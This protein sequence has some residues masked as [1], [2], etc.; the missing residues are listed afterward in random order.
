MRRGLSGSGARK[1][2]GSLAL[3]PSFPLLP[4]LAIFDLAIALTSPVTKSG[5]PSRPF[6]PEMNGIARQLEDGEGAPKDTRGYLFHFPALGLPDPAGEWVRLKVAIGRRDEC[7]ERML[8]SVLE[9]GH[10]REGTPAYKVIEIELNGAVWFLPTTMPLESDS[11]LEIFQL[12]VHRMPASAAPPSVRGKG[13][14]NATYVFIDRNGPHGKLR[15]EMGPL[16]PFERKPFSD[17]DMLKNLNVIGG[18]EFSIEGVQLYRHCNEPHLHQRDP[19]PPTSAS[20]RPQK[21]AESERA[22]ADA[23]V[24]AH[25]IWHLMTKGMLPEDFQ[26]Q[27]FGDA[28]AAGLLSPSTPFVPNPRQRLAAHIRVSPEPDGDLRGLDYA[29]SSVDEDEEPPTD[30]A[31]WIPF[32]PR[33]AE[34][35]WVRCGVNLK[36]YEMGKR[37]LTKD[38]WPP[39]PTSLMI[40]K[41]AGLSLGS[42]R[43]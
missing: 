10:L 35:N 37:L 5:P 9:G 1:R 14:D 25:N 26:R 41:L 34:E 11:E 21:K 15:L 18:A 43:R 42:G 19:F 12:D 39:K 38:D 29:L 20:S 28:I 36:R 7:F 40:S 32:P 23:L 24:K 30:E 8:H 17:E 33:L 13:V 4:Q 27:V 16:V 2:R 6:A 31:K 22:K 3:L